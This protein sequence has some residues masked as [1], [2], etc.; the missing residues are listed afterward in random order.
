MAAPSTLSGLVRSALALVAQVEQIPPLVLERA[1]LQ[2]MSAATA[3]VGAS[4]CVRD[5]DIGLD[6]SAGT[7]PRYSRNPSDAASAVGLH[8]AFAGWL[9]QDDLSLRGRSAAAIAAAAWAAARPHHSFGTVLAATIAGNELAG[10][11]GLVTALGAPSWECPVATAA[12]TAMTT[13]LLAGLT[14]HD[15]AR[16]IALA[17]ADMPVPRAALGSAQER[18]RADA[19]ACRRGVGAVLRVAAGAPD[20]GP[21]DVFD[22]GSPL[23]AAMSWHPLHGAWDGVGTVWLTETLSFRAHCCAPAIQTA[24]QSVAEVLRRHLKA[25]DKRLRVDQVERI[26]LVGPAALAPFVARGTGMAD[27]V[28]ASIPDAL[29]VLVARHALG[30]DDL[31][32]SVLE[33]ERERVA[34]IAD[35]VT[36]RTDPSLSLRTWVAQLQVLRPLLGRPPRAL[37]QR[38]L[39]GQMGPGFPRLSLPRRASLAPAWE[40]LRALRAESTSGSLVD[41]DVSAWRMRIPVEAYVFT[42]RGGRWPERRDLPDGSPGAAWETTVAAVSAR[43]PP[44][45][46]KSSA[47]AQFRSAPLSAPADGVVNGWLRGG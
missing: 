7:V 35:R 23:L 15:L 5:V 18:A 38:V 1:R 44:D 22:V 26:E 39:R 24:V 46:P 32:A 9:Q 13:G 45:H 27:S 6:S 31:Q 42:T 20:S 34:A 47:I 10:R 41:V 4:A 29:G 16:A 43:L 8:A 40:A 37:W 21:L 17:L 3:I 19:D 12:G 2:H 14:E 28:T 25:A 11:L 30:A 33:A 36:V